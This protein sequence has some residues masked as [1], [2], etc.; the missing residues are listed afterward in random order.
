MRISICLVAV[1]V[2]GCAAQPSPS[3]TPVTRQVRIDNSNVEAVQHA[4]YIIV[5]KDGEKLYCRTDTITGSRVQTHTSCL[6]ERE[7][8]AQNE[9]TRRSMEGISSRSPA[10]PGK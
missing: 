4:G 6:T 1:A 10:P 3:P 9:A 2:V 5:N 8:M 7:M